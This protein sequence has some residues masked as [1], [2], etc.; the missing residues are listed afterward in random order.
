MLNLFIRRKGVG[1]Q[2]ITTLVDWS[3]H[4]ISIIIKDMQFIVFNVF[5]R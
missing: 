3:T 5:Y 4:Y 2:V 1:S